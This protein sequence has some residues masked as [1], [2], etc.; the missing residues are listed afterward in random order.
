MSYARFVR[1]RTPAWDDFERRLA[2]SRRTPP[3]HDDLETLTFLYRRVLHDHAVVSHR[4]PR[5]G[6]SQRLRQLALEGTHAL[7][8]EPDDPRVGLVGFFTRSFPR[9]FRLY[10][11]HIAI[12]TA[13][14]ATALLLG[15]CL[16]TL[17]P[18]VGLALLG[19]EAVE[20]LKQG[21][22]WTEALVSAIPP[23]VSS[24]AIATNNM[25]VALTGWAGGAVAGLGAL[26]VA[27][28]NGFLLGAVV[29]ATWHYGMADA[30]LEF[31]SAHGPLEI[32]LI[33]VTAG[34][35]LGVGQALL[36]A[37]DRPRREAVGQAAQRALVVLLGCLPWFV[38]LGFVEGYVSPAPDVRSDLKLVLGVLLELLFLALAWNPAYAEER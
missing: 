20:G 14:F 13:I 17:Q 37:G 25:T 9:A 28:L 31:I 11:P 15:F 6:A 2:A 18:A 10:V 35:G 29:A 7:R 5:T 1:Q 22:L 12:V 16:S 8:L 27:L 19:P 23:A 3:S 21:R 24:S 36:A 26:Y 38:L 34:A 33:L 30:L 4:F 32:T